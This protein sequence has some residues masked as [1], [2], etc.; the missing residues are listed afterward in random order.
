MV[1]KFK[2]RSG[3][4]L[5]FRDHMLILYLLAA[6]SHQTYSTTT[7]CLEDHLGV[8]NVDFATLPSISQKVHTV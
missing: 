3:T 7:F 2:L 4:H 6:V 8:K 5:S 1:S